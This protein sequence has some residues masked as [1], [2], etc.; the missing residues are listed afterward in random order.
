MDKDKLISR[1]KN[2]LLQPRTEWPVI[3]AE[4]DTVGSLYTRYILILAALPVIAGFLKTTL[5]GTTVPLMGTVRIGFMAGLTSMILQYAVSLVSVYVLALIVNALAPTFGAQKDSVQ[6]LKTTAYASTA[7]W[8]A[9]ILVLVPWLGGLLAIAGS[10]YAFYLLFLAMPVTMRAPPEK[11]LPYTAVTVIIA[12]VLSLVLGALTASV[13]GFGA[14]RGGVELSSGDSTIKVDPDSTAGKLE[15]WSKKMEEAGKKM[16]A[17][18]K[19]G[20]QKAQLQAAGDALGTMFGGGDTV[21]ALKPDQ[22]KPFIP[23]KLGGMPRSDYSAERNAVM[24]LQTT[25]AGARYVDEGNAR[26]LRLEVTDLGGAK[27]LASLAGWA[28]QESERESD[29]GYERS[30]HKDGRMVQEEWNNAS[31]SGSYSLMIGER[32]SVKLQGQGVEMDELKSLATS[33]DLAGLEALKASGV[34]SGG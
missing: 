11:A 3:A 28:I 8:V 19:S 24:G 20:D 6:A 14:Y 12:I 23:E 1:V 26:S 21:E 32:F 9:G 25:T 15:A 17:A 27:G 16:D 29:S 2:I 10:L 34:K 31:Q 13:A 18:E 4:A 33:L 30:Y 22:L 5:I 7:S